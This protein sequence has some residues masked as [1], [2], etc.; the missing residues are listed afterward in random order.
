MN[1]SQ[2]RTAKHDITY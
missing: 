2:N 1:L